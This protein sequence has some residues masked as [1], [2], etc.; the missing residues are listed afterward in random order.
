MLRDSQKQKT[1]T[2]T[3]EDLKTNGVNQ[4]RNVCEL[5]QSMTVEQIDFVNRVAAL[6][7]AAGFNG[8][9]RKPGERKW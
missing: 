6:A 9:A 4:T 3:L 5:L 2:A 7:W 8:G 1:I